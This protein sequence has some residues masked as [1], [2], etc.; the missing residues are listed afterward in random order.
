MADDNSRSSGILSE[1]AF[2]KP[3]SRIN[4]SGA[5][6]ENPVEFIGNCV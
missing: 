3:A 1:I 5:A 4:T 6:F 2:E